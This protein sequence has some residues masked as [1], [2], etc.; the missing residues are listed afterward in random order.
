MPRWSRCA[1]ETPP[2]S[3]RRHSLHGLGRHCLLPLVLLGAKIQSQGTP[4]QTAS[5]PFKPGRLPRQVRHEKHRACIFTQK[6]LNEEKIS[7]FCFNRMQIRVPLRSHAL[8]R[9]IYLT[10]NVSYG[11][12]IPYLLPPTC[13]L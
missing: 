4:R 10:K 2:S 7:S 3:N 6:H 11:R 13:L 12:I 5:G 8:E 9:I 1:V